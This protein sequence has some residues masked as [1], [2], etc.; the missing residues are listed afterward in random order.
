MN[1]PARPN[2][3]Q[4]SRPT[5]DRI[6]DA[7]EVCFARRGFDG[8]TLRD[9]AERVG[10]RIPSLYNHFDGKQSIYAA[11]L[12]RGLAPILAMLARAVEDGDQE[13][14]PDPRRFV[15][16]VMETLAMHPD[17][18]RLVQYEM[19]A[20]GE[21]LALLL[22]GW[23]RPTM[24]RSLEL[25]QETPAARHWKP[26]QLPLLQLAL[27]NM[28]IGHF[29]MTPLTEQLLGRDSQSVLGLEQATDFYA[30]A[31][32]LLTFGGASQPSPESMHSTDMEHSK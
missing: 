5:P 24:E 3:D 9:I 2:T 23:L 14:P 12:A 27:V 20:G 32:G 19:L 16:E 22:E 8:T 4:A 25:L 29:T 10:I 21:N 28:L 31:A 26:D 17:L 30:Q 1:P 7:A 13:A 15:T 18:P 11:V 6:L